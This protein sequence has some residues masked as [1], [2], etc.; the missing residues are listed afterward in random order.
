MVVCLVA[1]FVDFEI[2]ESERP[3]DIF[4]RLAK[5]WKPTPLSLLYGL[6]WN[7]C[8]QATIKFSEL[9]DHIFVNSFIAAFFFGQIV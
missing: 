9:M 4:A 6:S 8:P 1:K 2:P 7:G 3:N 5:N